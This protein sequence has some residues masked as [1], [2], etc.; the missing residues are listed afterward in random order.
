MFSTEHE[1]KLSNQDVHNSPSH[2]VLAQYEE[3][4]LK[5]KE[6][7]KLPNS[8]KVERQLIILDIDTLLEKIYLEITKHEALRSQF[9][10]ISKS[11]AL[12]IN[13]EL[14]WLE[15]NAI[16]YFNELFK[17]EN[18]KILKIDF[19][20]K[21]DGDQLGRR[22]RIRYLTEN[23]EK[24]I[25]YFIKTHQN[26]SRRNGSTI[27]PVDPKEIFIYK[28]LELTHFGPKAHFFLNPLSIGSYFI[29]TQDEGFTKAADKNKFFQTYGHIRD[30]VEEKNDANSSK[31]A[32]REAIL[33]A[34]L[35]QR[36]FHLWDIVT[37]PG[38][39]GKT[40][41][42]DKDNKRSKWRI[43]DFRVSSLDNYNDSTIAEDFYA[44]QHM[45][46]Y[47]E[48]VSIT[49]DL[50][51][52]ERIDASKSIIDAFRSGRISYNTKDRKLKLLDAIKEAYCYTL[53]LLKSQNSSGCLG[54]DIE[55]ELGEMYGLDLDVMNNIEIMHELSLQS[56]DYSGDLGR[57]VK[58]TLLNT[59]L[60]LNSNPLNSLA[61]KTSEAMPD[62]KSD[63]EIFITNVNVI[64]PLMK[65]THS[66]LDSAEQFHHSLIMALRMNEV[67][68]CERSITQRLNYYAIINKE[69]MSIKVYGNIIDALYVLKK[70]GCI[71][72]LTYEKLIAGDDN[73]ELRKFIEI[74]RDISLFAEKKSMVSDEKY[75]T[76][77]P[78]VGLKL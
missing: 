15:R 78:S 5:I 62:G 71:T 38:N 67:S 20:S 25:F 73:Q 72:D 22:M 39:Y 42:N 30:S 57:Y 74:N 6:L 11:V 75:V 40:T 10:S 23:T 41:I 53:R 8:K 7:D 77:R 54:F 64:M 45:E 9:L 66:N 34:H 56:D 70:F 68:L 50:T 46:G 43:I 16:I 35:L 36:I 63:C 26:G 60:F 3:L 52:N 29:A 47:S 31:V 28:L 37:N 69:D 19:F 4:I 32:L 14:K 49:K 24:E 51:R 76:H 27:I 44:G 65:I 61:Y 18:K 21:L 48:L 13:S 1:N 59:T 33:S 12:H 55:K 58:A 2:E 17:R